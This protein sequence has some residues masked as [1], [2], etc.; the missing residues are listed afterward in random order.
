[1]EKVEIGAKE[2]RNRS[3]YGGEVLFGHVYFLYLLR[4]LC[5]PTSILRRSSGLLHCIIV[6]ALSINDSIK[7]LMADVTEPFAMAASEPDEDGG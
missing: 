4:P 3:V 1:M 5:F 6:S 2:A 7:V